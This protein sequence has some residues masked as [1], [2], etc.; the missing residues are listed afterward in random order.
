MLLLAR[1]IGVDFIICHYPPYSSKWNPIEHQV[2]PHLHRSMQGVVLSDY[3]L[4]QELMQKTKTATRLKIT[5]RINQKY[6]PTKIKTAKEE[7][8]FDRVQFHQ[9]LPKLSYRIVA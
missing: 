7:V 9:Q 5:V 3:Y 8:D 6:Y 2:F 1:E 4:V